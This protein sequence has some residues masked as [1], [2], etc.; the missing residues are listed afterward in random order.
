MENK[1]AKAVSETAEK[2]W[3]H[4]CNGQSLWQHVKRLPTKSWYCPSTRFINQ[5]YLFLMNLLLAWIPKQIIEVRELIASLAKT[6]YCPYS[7]LI[8]Y[9]RS[10]KP[11]LG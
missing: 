11:A 5:V 4:G 2:M 10:L 3:P 1:H 7:A 9:L 6:T 8:Y